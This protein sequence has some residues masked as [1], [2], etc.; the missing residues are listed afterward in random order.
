MDKNNKQ[1]EEAEFQLEAQI[2]CTKYHLKIFFFE[3]II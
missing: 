1:N 3:G 2:G